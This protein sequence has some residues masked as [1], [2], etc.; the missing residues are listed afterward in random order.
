M[1][2][3]LNC[4]E[5]LPRGKTEAGDLLEMLKELR[6]AL[7]NHSGGERL[8]FPRSTL[9]AWMMDRRLWDEIDGLDA[10]VRPAVIAARLRSR[11]RSA[12]GNR[13]ERFQ[14]P[15]GF[16]LTV[17][18][19]LLL[20]GVPAALFRA[21]VSGRFP[22]IGRPFKWFL[23]QPYL[24]RNSGSFLAFT[25]RLVATARAGEEP[26]KIDK[27]QVHAFLE[28]LRAAY[29]RRPWSMKGWRRTAYPVV[30]I[31]GAA[32][33]NP[34]HHF[35][36]LVHE[37]RRETA[38]RDPLLVICAGDA[39]AP[40]VLTAYLPPQNALPLRD[41]ERAVDRADPPAFLDYLPIDADGVTSAAQAADVLQIQVPP[42][43][44]PARSKTV[45]TAL[46]LV[47]LAPLLGWTVQRLGGLDCLHRP[48]AGQVSVRGIGGDCIGY[49]DSASFTF[50]DQPGQKKLIRIQEKIF[51]HNEQV[52][53]VWLRSGK[54][55]PYVTI[56]YL[57]SLTG[58]PTRADEEAYAAE[59]EELEGLAVAQHQGLQAAATDYAV[60]LVRIVVANAGFQMRHAATAVGMVEDLARRGGDAPV[61]GVVGL[62]ESRTTT[63]AALRRLH[64][65][66]LPVVAPTLSADGFA[67]NSK[68]YLQL[69]A[70]NRDQSRMVAA[71]AR[72]VL[73][74]K[75]A[76]VY[77][78]VGQGSSRE[79]DLYVDTLL[80]DLE[81][82]LVDLLETPVTPFTS[83]TDLR[84]VCGYQ[85]MVFFAG[86][87]S[88]F[89]SFLQA[90]K[91]CDGNPPRHLVA[92]DSVN[93]YVANTSLRH[94]A[95]GLPLT[96]V[97]KGAL[98]TCESLR[99]RVRQGTD[100]TA[101]SFLKWIG[102]DGVLTPPRC[103]G[104]GGEPVGERVGLAY[105]SAMLLL[106][107]VETLTA[108]VRPDGRPWEPERID[109][110]VV[111][112]EVLRKNEIQPFSGAAG[113]VKFSAEGGEPVDKRI[114][115]L[116]IEDVSKPPLPSVEVYHCGVARIGERP[117][118]GEGDGH[119]HR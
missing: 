6:V 60:P 8:W 101:H 9:A 109:P 76:R 86:R 95:P 37:V 116:R 66:G 34:A 39:Q 96:Y 64:Q 67:E 92:D 110:V 56:V 91:K 7:A 85:G 84:E 114:T 111:H 55:R 108:R 59:R 26:D 78:T 17:L 22:G 62:V 57:G 53:D 72:N 69:G 77:Y 98:A 47:L 113:T 25:E 35:L 102:T 45:A 90:L 40:A 105:D 79:E 16:V 54:R 41:V 89:S 93:R 24:A 15:E 74:V 87:W 115:L 71:Y 80:N 103:Q 28:D 48:F 82:D 12:Q 118:C 18:W 21:A 30:V 43:P 29:A 27:L 33:G 50:N 2:R 13:Q 32:P 97:S 1:L 112:T 83:G 31:E 20:Y 23:R 70:P 117:G 75:K 19:L 68:L 65:A 107:A 3:A 88:E 100:Q 104:E 11:G 119:G 58:R 36:R 14:P 61:V 4:Q 49:S 46:C 106:D 51:S 73:H 10:D 63:A 99:R 5:K 38:Q 94:H 81:D 52:H 44:W 42:P